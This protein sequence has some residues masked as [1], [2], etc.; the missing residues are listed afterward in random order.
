MAIELFVE[1]RVTK[2]WKRFCSDA[3]CFAIALDGYVSDAPK[4]DAERKIANFNHHEKVDRLAT[5]S[6]TGQV[7][8]AIKQGLFQTFCNVSGEAVAKIYVNDPDQDVATSVWLLRNHQRVMGGKSEPLITRMVGVVDLLD[9]TGGL[10]PLD[11]K[12]DIRR[13]LAWIFEPYVAFRKSGMLQKLN[14][15]E[16][17]S[18]IDVVG[19]RI[20]EYTLGRGKK[21]ALDCRYEVLARSEFGY[22]WAMIREIGLD[23]RAKLVSDGIDAFI[24]MTPRGVGRW[25]YTVAKASQFI[26]LEIDKVFFFLNQAEGI[27]QDASD[28]WGGGETIGGSPRASGSTL[29][30]ANVVKILE[31]H[32]EKPFDRKPENYQ[33]FLKNL[34]G[35]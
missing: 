32:C 15:D 16:M 23:A 25:T 11:P 29:S 8:V 21:T 27:S 22:P 13:E 30:P 12:M 2:S 33:E 28:K 24:S 5:R 35:A 17:A 34:T 1:P 7:Y 19:S 3:D 20:T 14:A 10:Y 26:P 18:I 31:W 6:T 4:F 9:T